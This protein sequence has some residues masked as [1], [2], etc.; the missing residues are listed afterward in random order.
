MSLISNGIHSIRVYTMPV[1]IWPDG[2]YANLPQTAMVQWSSVLNDVLYQVYVNGVYAGTTVHCD[3]RKMI[4]PVP[5]SFSSGVRIEVFGVHPEYAD[6]DLSSELSNPVDNNRIKLVL[7]RSQNL[8]PGATIKIYSDNGTGQIDYENPLTQTPIQV[9]PSW[10]DKSGFGMS[11]FG[12]SDFGYDSSAAIGF[13]KGCFGKNQFGMDTDTI[14]WTSRVLPVGTYKFAIIV[15][16]KAG[17]KSSAIET[18][19]VTLIPSAEPVQIL[20]VLS[21]DKQANELILKI[22]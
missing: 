17:N 11:K 16:D 21:Y 3:Q 1:G 6:I 20:E 5:S 7:S 14:E 13:G 8:P 19:A 4:V 15:F 10:K 22:T 18:E 12:F 9:W 2:E